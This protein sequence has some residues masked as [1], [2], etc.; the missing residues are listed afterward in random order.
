[1]GPL[2]ERRLIEWAILGLLV[3][4]LAG[5]LGY[6]GYRVQGQAERAAV[7]ST[8]G[9]L[10]TALVLDR[11]RQVLP[12]AGAPLASSD[13]F[14]TL[15][16]LPANYA[17]Q[18]SG[19]DVTDVR[20]GSWVFDAGCGCIGYKPLR[21][22]WLEGTP[23]PSALWFRVVEQRGVRQLEP[24]DAYAWLGQAVR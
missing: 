18:V 8:L 4:A 7:Q 23:G 5:S 13:P 22:E 15:E 19:R 21:P 14:A 1:M 3:L 24:M 9:A 2:W 16:A 6:Y 20:A 10:R 12:S 17:G 11:L